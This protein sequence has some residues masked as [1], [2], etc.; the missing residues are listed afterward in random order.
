MSEIIAGRR[1]EDQRRDLI[2]TEK[3]L[4]EHVLSEVRD[5]VSEIDDDEAVL[6]PAAIIKRLE[7]I[8][9][10][11]GVALTV[12]ADVIEEGGS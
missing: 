6:T 11:V 9:T 7:R 4:D 2:W 1:A 12:L 5:L 10:A 3:H 8:E